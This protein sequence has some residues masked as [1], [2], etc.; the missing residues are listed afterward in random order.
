MTLA[1]SITQ[2]LSC[3]D[4]ICLAISTR[5]FYDHPAARI[6]DLVIR[7]YV[8]PRDTDMDFKGLHVLTELFAWR[9]ED[10]GG[11]SHERWLTRQAEESEAEELDG[12]G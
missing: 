9:F 8:F 5:L 3:E 1:I 7:S 4:R 11:N 6:P 2:A 10:C 12:D